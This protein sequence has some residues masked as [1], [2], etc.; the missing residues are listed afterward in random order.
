LLPAPAPHLHL[1]GLAIGLAIGLAFG[2]AWGLWPRKQSVSLV[3]FQVSALCPHNPDPSEDWVCV[4][5]LTP[6]GWMYNSELQPDAETGIVYSKELVAKELKN[7]DFGM[8]L[9]GRDEFEFA[10]PIEVNYQEYIDDGFDSLV[11]FRFQA[12]SIQEDLRKYWTFDFYYDDFVVV[13]GCN[14]PVNE[15]N[16]SLV[17]NLK[18]TGNSFRGCKTNSDC[19]GALGC[20]TCAVIPS[21]HGKFLDS[22]GNKF[23]VGE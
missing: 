13:L 11:N 10:G 12:A 17:N 16:G 22:F 20:G 4:T 1:L 9:D 5:N 7:E 18:C 3:S 14:S 21:I 19:D 8:S 6:K 23:C 15:D 2:L